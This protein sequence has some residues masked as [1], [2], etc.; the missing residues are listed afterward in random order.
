MREQNES[1]RFCLLEEKV[2]VLVFL[3]AVQSRAASKDWARVSA[4]CNRTIASIC[5][6]TSPEFKV[7]LVCNEAPQLTVRSPRLEILTHDFPLP[8][9]NT[10][11]RMADKFE[12]I[13]FAAYA[14]RNLAPAYFM[15]ADADDCVSNRLVHFVETQ[16]E[17][18]GW[19]LDE[20]YMHEQGSR[21]V[22]LRDNFHVFCGTSSIIR[23]TPEDL[24]SA[25]KREE[26]RP[27]LVYVG[28]TQIKA[29]M[30]SIGRPLAQLP[31]RGAIYEVGTGENDSG[32]SLRSWPS[33]RTGIKRL[34]RTR[35]MTE[36]IRREFGSWELSGR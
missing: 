14:V 10:K 19:Y 23:C 11:S 4:L 15:T 36:S 20:S 1:R 2:Q 18:H 13:G 8:E 3:C 22:F 29:H 16:H 27:S 21:W 5:A 12:K 30:E 7:V 24:P 35:P 17:A 32:L 6:Q 26:S 9:P 28:H 25:A 33:I 34:A 31:F